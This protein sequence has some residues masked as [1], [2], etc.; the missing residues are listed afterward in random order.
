MS[1]ITI[2]S[3]FT[4]FFIKRIFS[5]LSIP[6][7]SFTNSN[8]LYTS[9][10]KEN[11]L[12]DYVRNGQLDFSQFYI[13]L[14]IGDDRK[15]YKV[16][17]DSTLKQ[18]LFFNDVCQNCS[19]SSIATKSMTFEKNKFQIFQKTTN[20]ILS[21]ADDIKLND[22]PIDIADDKNLKNKLNSYYDGFLG[23]D[24]QSFK[25]A[26]DVKDDLK[27]SNLLN[28]LYNN[29]FID[30]RQFSFGLYLDN[31]Q[32]RLILGGYDPSLVKSKFVF[33][34]LSNSKNWM[35]P[36]SQIVNDANET[37]NSESKTLLF[38]STTTNLI[39][40]KKDVD[41]LVNMINNYLQSKCFFE[42]SYYLICECDKFLLSRYLYRELFKFNLNQSYYSF[43]L[44][45]LLISKNWDDEK[46]T[47]ALGYYI[48]DY[49]DNRWIAGTK[50]FEKYY[51]LFNA[52]SKYI[53]I[54]EIDF[55]TLIGKSN[56]LFDIIEEETLLVICFFSAVGV[57]I[58]VILTIFKEGR[59][60]NEF[61]KVQTEDN[62]VFIEEKMHI[63]K[64]REEK[65]KVKLNQKSDHEEFELKE[66]Q[67]KYNDYN[68]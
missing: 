26:K 64:N 15:I 32:S 5:I 7:H 34:R 14:M 12:I 17:V 39:G 28:Y 44:D 6:L 48:N 30:V 25:E 37:I 31:N 53:A 18:N 2:L 35:I 55:S 54:A 62:E 24:L 23:L 19:D 38:D 16:G 56:K 11:N 51:V 13:D 60:S 43:N 10:L 29:N 65:N 61:E 36:L 68:N 45:D 22:Y 67:R 49:S 33:H 63:S 50:F 4:L 46:C 47:F 57:L 52:D 40:P 20:L 8:I 27:N 59:S 9:T 58:Y 1:K 42:N 66:I 3:I 41:K 21:D